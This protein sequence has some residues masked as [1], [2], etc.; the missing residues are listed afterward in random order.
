MKPG[1]KNKDRKKIAL[2]IIL[3]SITVF[4]SR[5]NAQVKKP[6]TKHKAT[7]TAGKVPVLNKIDFLSKNADDAAQI[8]SDEFKKLKIDLNDI[9]DKPVYSYT[10]SNEKRSESVGSTKILHFSKGL[11]IYLSADIKDIVEKLSFITPDGKHYTAIKKMLGFAA[12]QKVSETDQDTT[13][14]NAG[15]FVSLNS[16]KDEEEGNRYAVTIERPEPFLYQPDSLQIS[17]IEDVNIHSGWIEVDYYV[18]DFIK[19]LGYSYLYNSKEAHLEDEKGKRFC[20]IFSSYFSNGLSVDFTRGK[21]RLLQ[22]IAFNARNPIVFSKLKKALHVLQWQL[23]GSDQENNIEYYTNNNVDCAI[24]NGERTINFTI[25]PALTDVETRLTEA[26]SLNFL[27]LVALYNTGSKQE[28]AKAITK[29]YL[30]KAKYDNNLGKFVFDETA[31]DYL[32]YYTSPNDFLV[33]VF[34]KMDLTE[35]FTRPILVASNDKDYLVSLADELAQSEYKD[36]YTK[37]LTENNFSIYDNEME[38]IRKQSKENREAEA[39]RQQEETD[40][41]QAE[42]KEQARLA[43]IEKQRLRD[44]KAA[45]T[46]AA[47]EKLNEAL[48]NLVKKQ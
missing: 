12:W 40:R 29:T 26:P 34:F 22:T 9:E 13:Y 18:I 38:A 46:N 24:L 47:L 19:K 10:M 35:D 8:L 39:R 16:R 28:V 11:K 20:S 41:Q 6:V 1:I 36:K 5:L 42:A 45:R 4:S 25:H 2:T 27:Q 37:G 30:N 7:L 43:D 17:N 3:I 32:F 15:T 48:R 21:N 44:E 31:D 14:K 23:T 33:T